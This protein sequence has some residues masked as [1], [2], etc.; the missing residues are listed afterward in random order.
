M[1]ME[2]YTEHIYIYI[3]KYLVVHFHLTL[4]LSLFMRTNNVRDNRECS[5]TL[6]FLTI[7]LVHID[8]DEIGV[9]WECTTKH[10]SLSLSLSLYI[11]IYI[12]IYTLL[13]YML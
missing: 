5:G 8:K 4:I 7:L 3:Q 1:K 12:Y 6:I 2:L 11:Y 13:Q 10:L 9:V